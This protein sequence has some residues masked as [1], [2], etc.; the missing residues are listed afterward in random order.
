[1]FYTIYTSDEYYKKENNEDRICIICWLDDN[2][3]KLCNLQN[4]NSIITCNCNV[5]IHNVC[6]KNW[7][8]LNHSCPICRKYLSIK[9]SND[10]YSN[11][12]IIYYS[13]INILK[14]ANT[15]SFINLI[16][17]FFFHFYY[18]YYVYYL[19]YI[20]IEIITQQFLE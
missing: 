1:M 15:I 18:T 11:Y 2:K 4:S 8:L 20:N 7:I 10:R 3:N 14:I 16:F 17:L 6:L 5:I 12:Y 19:V 9:K 13:I